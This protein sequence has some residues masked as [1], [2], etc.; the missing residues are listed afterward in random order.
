MFQPQNQNHCVAFVTRV[1][2]VCVQT[3]HEI[4]GVHAHRVRNYSR[5]RTNEISCKHAKPRPLT[6]NGIVKDRE[7]LGFGHLRSTYAPLRFSEVGSIKWI[8]TKG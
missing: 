5:A 1:N 6:K 7:K 3:R 8:K 2:S 4:R